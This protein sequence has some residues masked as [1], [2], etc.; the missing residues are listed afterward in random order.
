M[1]VMLEKPMLLDSGSGFAPCLRWKHDKV[2][3]AG[4]GCG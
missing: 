2:T 3:T 1:V 4:M